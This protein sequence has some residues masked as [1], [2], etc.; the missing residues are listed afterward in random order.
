MKFDYRT[1]IANIKKGKIDSLY[2]FYGPQDYLKEEAL[3]Q[4]IGE[5]VDPQLS[6][7][8]LDVLF[9]ADTDAEE[10]FNLISTVPMN[11]KRRLV[12]VREAQRLSS[13]SKNRL[14]QLLPRRP[15]TA[16]LVLVFTEVK[17]NQRFYQN[18]RKL[19]NT[20]EFGNLTPGELQSWLASR[21]DSLG[22][23]ISPQVVDSLLTTVGDNL[24]DL[25]NELEKLAHF[26][27]ERSQ[28]RG[29]DVQ[30]IFGQGH[31]NETW[32]ILDLVGEKEVGP[33]LKVLSNLLAYRT[34]PGWITAALRRHYNG[35]YLLKS[36]NGS[37]F[38]ELARK[39]RIPEY[40]WEVYRRQ[41]STHSLD[42]LKEKIY[43][44]Y[45]A[46]L[47]LRGGRSRKLVLELLIY[48]LCRS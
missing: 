29:E 40:K 4:L 46:E 38:E 31:P 25:A 5:L 27:G 9:G 45:D 11:A 12:I 36:T 23:K 33:A 43:L 19:A 39:L 42:E 7:F 10:I 18:L 3:S 37:H 32:E 30:A 6:S 44:L 20:V 28:I 26:V 22:K 35:L 21:A 17:F 41:L 24:L 34:N 2:F 1:L 14:L 16:T 48:N 13:A 15:D 8:N 47:D